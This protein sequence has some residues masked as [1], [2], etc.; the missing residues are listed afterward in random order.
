ME[1]WNE[2]LGWKTV[3]TYEEAKEWQEKTSYGV[4]TVEPRDNYLTEYTDTPYLTLSHTYEAMILYIID[5]VNE[6]YP[7]YAQYVRV[8]NIF[9][10]SVMKYYVS[11]KR[12]YTKEK[13][14]KFGFIQTKHGATYLGTPHFQEYWQYIKDKEVIHGRRSEYIDGNG[15]PR[16]SYLVWTEIPREELKKLVDDKKMIRIMN[17]AVREGQYPTHLSEEIKKTYKALDK[18]WKLRKGEGA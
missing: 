7:E 9:T 4:Q 6:E 2:E 8:A 18:K 13:P 16:E 14:I 11:Q 12:G 3:N 17:G 10:L 5:K 1:A 15:K